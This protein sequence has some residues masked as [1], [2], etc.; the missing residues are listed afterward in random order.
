MRN[1]KKSDFI[2]INGHK[3]E[4]VEDFRLL[5][6]VIDDKLNFNSY[7]SALKQ[8]VNS[9]LFFMKKL[10]SLSLSVKITFFKSF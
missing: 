1:I 2:P 7:Y 9:K 4:V 5:A 6:I 3:I 10:N 8:S